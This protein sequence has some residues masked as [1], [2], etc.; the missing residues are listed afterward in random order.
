LR[1]KVSLLT[2]N[3]KESK[4]YFTQAQQIAEQWGLTQVLQKITK[5][6]EVFLKQIKNWEKY[7]EQ[8]VSLSE[9]VELARLDKQIELM[10]QN[11][12]ELVSGIVEEKVEV[13]TER[14]ICMICR[15]DVS[16][17]IY[18][19]DCNTI[20]CESCVKALIDL[21]NACWVCES[22]IDPSKPTKHFRRDKV[23]VEKK[24]H[25]KKN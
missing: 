18:V 7:K 16:R 3:L 4:R 13:H 8:E 11:R 14:K 9:R 20:Y 6:K 24:N 19:C 5:E 10:L 12:S 23:D 22:S 17:Y 25:Y 1:A 2:F 15:G 21:E